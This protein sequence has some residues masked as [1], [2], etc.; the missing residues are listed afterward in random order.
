M[1]EV[2][3]TEEYGYGRP[4]SEIVLES[5]WATVRAIRDAN[6]KATDWVVIQSQETGEPIPDAW[7]TY[8]QALRD[9]PQNQTDPDA[10]VW[11]EKPTV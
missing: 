2:N 10:V 5:K 9:I 7:K 4:L 8:R 11:P 3:T 1:S 6:L